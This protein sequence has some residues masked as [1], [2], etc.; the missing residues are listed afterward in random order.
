LASNKRKTRRGWR[1]RE[2]TRILLYSAFIQLTNMKF[3][4][5]DNFSICVEMNFAISWA[6]RAVAASTRTEFDP[7]ELSNLIEQ[8][9]FKSSLHLS[10]DETTCGNKFEGHSIRET[11][12]WTRLS[13]ALVEGAASSMETTSSKRSWPLRCT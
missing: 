9:S 2:T 4:S 5:E 12:R 1:K 13:K 3:I 11:L 8:T 7:I 6:A 10:M